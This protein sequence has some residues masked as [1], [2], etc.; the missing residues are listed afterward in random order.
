MP[1]IRTRQRDQRSR[2][3]KYRNWSPTADA[4][5]DGAAPD[6]S[7]AY[8][9]IIQR[10]PTVCDTCFLV[11]YDIT[12]VE[13]WRGTFGWSEY[14]KWDAHPDTNTPIPAAEA[15]EGMRLACEGC[16]ARTGTKLRPIPS[17]RIE[18][19]TRHLSDALAGKQ[20][21]HDTDVLLTEVRERN[22][23]ENQMR[24]DSH[25]FAPAVAAAIRAIQSGATASRMATDGG[26][27]R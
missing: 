9:D 25:V 6:P 19:Y 1:H 23:S 7:N 2:E 10:D 15:S 17:D 3:A 18:Q 12:A 5:D 26:H 20:I 4:Q 8:Q 21:R 11:R 13:W 22:T 16:G 27:D 14:V 24:Q